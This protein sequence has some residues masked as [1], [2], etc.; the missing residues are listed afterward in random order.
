MDLPLPSISHILLTGAGFTHN[1]GAPLADEMWAWIFNGPEVKSA[2]RVHALL[3]D[4]FD[5]EDAYHKVMT[6]T[7]TDEEKTVIHNAVLQAYERIDDI[8]RKWSPGSGPIGRINKNK[9]NELLALFAGNKRECG[10]FFTLNQS[11]ELIRSLTFMMLAWLFACP[12]GP[13]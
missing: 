6:G 4:N 2:E 5:Y 11:N 1:F 12:N 3:R 9:I 10:F 8:M 13:Q 7:Y